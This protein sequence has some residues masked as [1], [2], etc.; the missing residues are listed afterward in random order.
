MR[1]HKS[2]HRFYGV[3]KMVYGWRNGLTLFLDAGE[4]RVG[5]QMANGQGSGWSCRG[6]GRRE[7]RKCRVS[8]SCDV[9]S[10][11]FWTIGTTRFS[12]I[13]KN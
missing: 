4:E 13:S 3:V 6:D 12:G 9:D 10:L 5:A 7:G 11:K 1:V 8:G 2:N